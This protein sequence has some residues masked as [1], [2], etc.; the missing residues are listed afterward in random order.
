MLLMIP[1]YHGVIAFFG[2]F[3]MGAPGKLVYLLVA[4]VW[5]YAAWA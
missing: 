2:I 4:G 3:L 1:A 5:A